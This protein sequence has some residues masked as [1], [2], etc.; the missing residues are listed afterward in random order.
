[1]LKRTVSTMVALMLVG[2]VAHAAPN[3]FYLSDKGPGE[4]ASLGNP[5]ITMNLGETK[6]LYVWAVPVE[7]LVS[8]DFDLVSSDAAVLQ[9]TS[10][11]TENPD[12]LVGTTD[13]GQRWDGVGGTFTGDLFNFANG[14]GVSEYGLDAA[15]DGSGTFTDA[16]YDPTAQA[17]LYA[18]VAIQATGLGVTD[19]DLLIHD[20]K[21]VA[22]G[23][24]SATTEVQL[25]SGETAILYGNEVGVYSEFHDGKVTVVPEPGTLA[26]LAIGGLGVLLRKKR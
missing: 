6:T 21:I 4:S 16:G 8:C 15:N 11:Q 20:N 2:G 18:R 22:H 3:V 19:L 9:A 25:G 10:G 23:K 1:M 17:F 26:L 13:V 5:D 12:I 24:T 14:A 7:K